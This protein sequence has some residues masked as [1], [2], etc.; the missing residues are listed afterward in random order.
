MTEGFDRTDVVTD[1]DDSPTLVCDGS[2]LPEALFLE[3]RIADRQHL[4]HEENLRLQVCGDGE[5]QPHV[6]PAREALDRCVD[7]LLHLG[8]RDDLVEL[9]SDFPPFHAE[10]RAVE[11][12]VLASRQFGMKTRPY[13]QQRPDAAVDLNPARCR[14]CDPRQDLEQRALARSIPSDHADHFSTPDLEADIVQGPDAGVAAVRPAPGASCR[15]TDVPERRVDRVRQCVT[16]RPVG[17]TV[18]DTVALAQMINAY[19][20]I[21]HGCHTR[22]ANVFSIRAK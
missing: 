21:A 1:K 17:L 4:V 19:C 16:Q 13:L 20:D 10:D 18:P 5:G 12:N 2:H 6:H 8:E 7:E 22:S 9:S 3:R 11:V 14:P 15:R